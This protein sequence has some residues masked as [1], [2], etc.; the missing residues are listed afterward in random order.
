MNKIQR[1]LNY[2]IFYVYV[3]LS[4][5]RNGN[6]GTPVVSPFSF[7]QG[8]RLTSVNTPVLFYVFKVHVTLFGP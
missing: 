1:D 8:Q 7:S 4:T 3:A 5:K 6:K 2:R